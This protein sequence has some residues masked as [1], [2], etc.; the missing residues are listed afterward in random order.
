[1]S[2]FSFQ[3]CTNIFSSEGGRL[4]AELVNVPF[5]GKIPIELKLNQTTDKKQSLQITA[6]ESAAT[7]V[8]N[9]IV[10]IILKLSTNQ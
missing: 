1:M 7:A 2:Y 10:E 9:N 6:P 8:F 5:L 4:L 3:E